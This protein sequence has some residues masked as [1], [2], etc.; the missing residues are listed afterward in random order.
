M[1]LTNS[2]SKLK[3]SG[4]KNNAKIYTF[5]L[6]AYKTSTGKITCPFAKDCVKFCY[7]QKG[8]YKL[9]QKWAEL[10]FEATKKDTF[11]NDMIKD[12]KDKKADYIRVHDSGDYYSKE[13]LLKWFKI[14]EK[15]PKIRFYSYTK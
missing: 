3:K 4:L 1:M 12:I 2:N 14:A 15:L 5:D 13:Y 6:P 8:F 10:K 7:A 11:I 9:S